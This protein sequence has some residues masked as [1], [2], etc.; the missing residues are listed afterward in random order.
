MKRGSRVFCCT[1][2]DWR[3]T[4]LLRR[5]IAGADKLLGL[6]WGHSPSK[7]QALN[8]V[9]WKAA[10]CSGEAGIYCWS[11]QYA[12]NLIFVS[13]SDQCLKIP[14]S[15]KPCPPL[16]LTMVHRVRNFLYPDPCRR[17]AF[18]PEACGLIAL[19]LGCINTVMNIKAVIIVLWSGFFS[20][21]IL[22]VM[23]LNSRDL[24]FFICQGSLLSR[25]VFYFYLLGWSLVI[26]F[27]ITLF[28]LGGGAV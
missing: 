24:F 9:C 7:V 4:G 1:L 11:T 17:S 16:P 10:M 2:G 18:C 6:L 21:G 27:H 26:H 20:R 28:L 13:S 14:E 22:L 12:I 23:D 3:N 15:S 5:Q 25:I 8:S 19:I